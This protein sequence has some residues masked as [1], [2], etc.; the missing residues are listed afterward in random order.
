MA[1]EVEA[2]CRFVEHAGGEA[3]IGS[4]FELDAISGGDAGTRIT[5]ARSVAAISPHAASATIRM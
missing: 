1:P 5:H 2:A 3:V 4:L